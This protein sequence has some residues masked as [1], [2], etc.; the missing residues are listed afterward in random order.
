MVS[1]RHAEKAWTQLARDCCRVC[2]KAWAES[3]TDVQVRRRASTQP[4]SRVTSQ[5]AA[6]QEAMVEVRPEPCRVAPL[7][8]VRLRAS[9]THT[10]R[11]REQ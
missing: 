2:A 9:T 7:A 10:R 8:S 5:A 4:H 1:S 3:R 11:S 6:I